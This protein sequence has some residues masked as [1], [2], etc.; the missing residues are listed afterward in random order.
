VADPTVILRRRGDIA[1]IVLHRPH[2]LNAMNVAWVTDL[3]DA[4]TVVAQ[5]KPELVVIRGE[6]RAFCAGM[7]LDMLAREGLPPAFYPLQEQ[8]FSALEQLDR[9]VIAQ[10]HGYCL[11]GGL[12]LALAC[13]IRIVSDDAL[14]GLP[15][16][17]EGL[18]PGMA[19]WRLPR[20][21][22]LG[23]TLRLAILGERI[24]ADEALHAGLVDHVLAAD[25]FEE[26]ARALVERYRLVPQAAARATKELARS[27]FDTDFAT[28]YARSRELVRQCMDT[29]D[30]ANARAAWAQRRRE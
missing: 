7:D 23:R 9:L 29:A 2:K 3:L 14:L 26:H 10:I 6:G 25:G 13:D 16:A 28:I 30:A 22:G 8:A 5:D 27:S 11:G 21:I 17:S 4:V 15:A 12:Q 1:E 20:Y 24:G 19:P 18:P